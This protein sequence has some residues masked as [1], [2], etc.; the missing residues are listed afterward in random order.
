MFEFEK[1]AAGTKAIM[2]AVVL[3]TRNGATTIIG[4]S[5]RTQPMVLLAFA[6]PVFILSPTIK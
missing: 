3:A 4:K 2:D 5:W 6:D 1:F